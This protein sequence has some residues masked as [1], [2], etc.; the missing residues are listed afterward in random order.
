LSGHA[1]HAIAARQ[2]AGGFGGMLAFDVAGGKSGAR[3]FVEELRLIRLATSL[4]SVETTADLPAITS[5]SPSMIDPA[6]R[7][8]LGIHESTVRLSV[9]C[10]DVEDLIEDLSAALERSRNAGTEGSQDAS[11]AASVR[12]AR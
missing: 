3:A 7:D 11:A 8:A 1:A 12:T 6:R 4:G 10:E 2:M 5:H 9:G